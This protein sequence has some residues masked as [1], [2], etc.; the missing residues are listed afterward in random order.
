M[1]EAELHARGIELVALAFVDNAG[2]AR[3]KPV[4]AAKLASAARGGVGG[5]PGFA[6]FR[7]DDVHA[8]SGGLEVPVGDWRLIA[9]L[10]S[11]RGGVDG[12]GFCAGD[13]HSQDGEP[14]PLCPRLF[15]KRMVERAAQAGFTL[16]M[17]FELEWMAAR[18]QA[19]AELVHE[20]PAYGL[21]AVARS[22]DY[23]RE[24]ARRLAAYG[25]EVEQLHAEYSPGQLEAS[26]A[27]RDPVTACDE[28]VLARHAI[29]QATA[30]TGV[31][32]SFAP[33][34]RDG[35]IGNGAHLHVSLWRDGV[36]LLGTEEP[37]G[38]SFLAGVL[39]EI[40][41]IV[42][43]GL[44]SPLSWQRLGPS[45]WTSIYGCWGVEN[46]EA[47]IRFVWGSQVSRPGAT[48]FELKV[49]DAS[50]NPYLVA[51]AAIAAGLGG[52]EAGRACPPP[53]DLDPAAL[54]DAE[55]QARGITPLPRDAASGAAALRASD[56]LG[57]ALGVRLRDAI[58]D[59]HESEAAGWEARLDEAPA[60]YR[61]RY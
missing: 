2:I 39:A 59:V 33:F 53:L 26:F 5:W 43:L 10:G 55:R 41:A 37:E 12:W 28:T 51:G 56:V 58:A 19:F 48:N 16:Q 23:L 7:G 38:R 22:G 20:G 44:S 9:D 25:L 18:D 27:P 40:D 46:R 21:T 31:E 8:R 14:W 61:L 47:P 49:L 1:T 30:A 13:Q 3:A 42:G 17:T 60:Y 54:T 29:H 11:L 24:I 57:E 4:V 52:I 32:A 34:V 15:L 6:I 36:N 50:A 35:L 45:R